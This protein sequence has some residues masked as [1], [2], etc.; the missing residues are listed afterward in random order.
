MSDLKQLDAE[1]DGQVNSASVLTSQ[2]TD[3]QIAA[4][5]LVNDQGFTAPLAK[6]F[7][8][9]VSQFAR[10]DQVFE[11]LKPPHNPMID[12][13]HNILL[14]LEG[15]SVSFDG[16]KAINDLNLYIKEGE[17]RCIIGP[18]GA[19]KTTMMDII[20]GKTKPDSGHVWLGSRLNLLKMDEAQI[21]N[22]GVGRKFQK[23]TVFP[24]I[25]IPNHYDMI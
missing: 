6:K 20:T 7:R 10:R 8:D 4:S 16:F 2:F 23:P 15:V 14:Y 22:A 24:T 11:F 21:A 1:L 5:P 12:T 18:N 17:L 13:R 25:W 19:G 9:N 3:Q